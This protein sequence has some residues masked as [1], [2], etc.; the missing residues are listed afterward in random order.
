MKK[1]FIPLFLLV[2]LSA[3]TVSAGCSR[4][5]SSLN[6]SGKIID[7]EIEVAGFTE[8]YVEGPFTVE[9]VRAAEYAVTLS[10]DDNMISRVLISKKDQVLNLSIQAPATFFP[11]TLKVK[12]SMPEIY[13]LTLSGSA[14]AGISEFKSASDFTLML[15]DNSML[16]G[17]IELSNAS[18]D[19]SKNSDVILKGKAR[20]LELNAAE[21]SRLDLAEFSLASA[22][23]KLRNLSEAT[24]NVTETLDVDLSGMSKLYYIGNPVISH[25]SVSGNSIMKQ[26]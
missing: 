23:I 10:V 5:G 1:M 25:S 21:T 2:A 20:H 11:T 7:R 17:Y 24:L 19:I 9:I 12:I 16:G 26:Q 3:C 15:T 14:R 22:E 13:G 4:V 18:F 8:I 6:G